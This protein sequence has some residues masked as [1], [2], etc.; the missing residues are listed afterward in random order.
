LLKGY[1]LLEQVETV[2]LAGGDQAQNS[3]GYF[4]FMQNPTEDI[5]SG[6]H[7]TAVNAALPAT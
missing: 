1:T 5:F 4:L 7:R 3:F 6:S 2:G